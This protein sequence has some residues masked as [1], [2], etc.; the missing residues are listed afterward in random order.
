MTFFK[1]DNDRFSIWHHLRDPTHVVFCRDTTLR[2]IAG[3][4]G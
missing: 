4:F 3:R 1:T 2:H